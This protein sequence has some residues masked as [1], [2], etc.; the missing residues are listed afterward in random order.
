MAHAADHPTRF[1]CTCR[2]ADHAIA[3]GVHQVS[4]L[5]HTL[6]RWGQRRHQRQALQDLDAHQLRDIGISRE[7][8]QREASKPFWA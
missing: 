1:A 8:A 6:R 4:A 5:A 3:S 2:D 7:D